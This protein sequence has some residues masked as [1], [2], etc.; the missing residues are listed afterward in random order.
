[1][2]ITYQMAQMILSEHRFKK[3]TGDVLLLGRQTVFMSPDQA[4]KLLKEMG[5][6]IRKEAKIEYDTETIGHQN[7]FISDKSFF[8]LFSDAKVTSSDVSSYEGAELVFDLS[9][10]LPGDLSRKFDFIYNGSVLDNVFDPAS[11]IKNIK[12][13]W[14]GISL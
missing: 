3:I 6:S 2:A 10:D 11:S 7:N 13:R 8:S 14:S 5:I 4:K 1:M 12:R 9:G